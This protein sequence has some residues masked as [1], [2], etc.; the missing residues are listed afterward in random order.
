MCELIT[1]LA[2]NRVPESIVFAS[3]LTK[4]GCPDARKVPAELPEVT[5]RTEWEVSERAEVLDESVLRSLRPHS[6]VVLNLFRESTSS[7]RYHLLHTRLI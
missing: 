7:S 4:Y 5:Y 3:L 6:D 2:R 1:F